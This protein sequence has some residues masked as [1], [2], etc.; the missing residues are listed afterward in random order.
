MDC[1]KQQ[2]ARARRR[3]AAQQF[4]SV[5][6]WCWLGTM[7]AAV[8]AVGVQK[9][10]LPDIDGWA[11]AAQWLAGAV[12]LGCLAAL[13]WTLVVR[14]GDLDAAMEIDRRFGLKER[15]SS[16]L[17][18]TADERTSPCGQALVEETASRISQLTVAERFPVRISRRMLLPLAP[19]A[20]AIAICLLPAATS[21]THEGAEVDRAVA[22][23][24]V[25]ESIKPLEKK[26]ERR[27]EEAK[28]QGLSQLAQLLKEIAN[29]THNLVAKEQADRH[30]TL[31]ELHDL[32]RELNQR[33]DQLLQQA[34]IKQAFAAMK[35]VPSGPADK[36]AQELKSGNFERALAELKKLQE[37]LSHGQLGSKRQTE[38]AEQTAAMSQS[39]Q[40]NL[41]QRQQAQEKLQQQLAAARQSGDRQAARRLEQQ[42]ANLDKQQ[43]PS[44][45]IKQFADQLA[46]CANSAKSR[47]LDNVQV[48]LNQLAVRLGQAQQ[49]SQELE[50][51][52]A[53]LGDIDGAKMA[54]AG[55]Q[56][57]I[58]DASKYP[59]RTA[60]TEGIGHRD[61]DAGVVPDAVNAKTYDSVV[62][63]HCREARD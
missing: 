31:A 6:P 25:R 36:L 4:L 11:W 63:A 52:E 42:A 1:L 57:G 16:S 41:E 46:Q 14:R 60:G 43:R 59:S 32:T 62:K 51:I 24:Q 47:N 20:V 12:A 28:E 45:T 56:G 15:V 2:V 10:F 7:Q 5:L 61:G 17:A 21:F 40:K 22:A 33:S 26:V 8:A 30:E 37:Q 29:R 53:T 19:A 48:A 39:L 18:L 55:K 44:D 9:L 54:M 38:L 35:E 27:A 49:P 3:L 50:M 13:V 58:E 23:K 34:K